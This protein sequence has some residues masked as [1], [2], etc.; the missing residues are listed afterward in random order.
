MSFATSMRRYPFILA[1]VSV[2]LCLVLWIT[3]IIGATRWPWMF[4][5]SHAKRANEVITAVD[6]F[7]SRTGSLPDN[8]EELGFKDPE[9][10]E[11]YYQK[12]NESSYVVWF[13]TTLGESAIYESSTKERH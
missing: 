11:V 13:G 3:Y 9:S 8:L 5:G 10:L 4:D 2:G 1:A 7:R 12:K 6:S